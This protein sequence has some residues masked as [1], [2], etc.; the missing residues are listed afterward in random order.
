MT[1]PETERGGMPD[2][3]YTRLSKDVEGSPTMDWYETQENG[4]YPYKYHADHIHQ[5]A[6]AEIAELRGLVEGMS[7]SLADI[8]ILAM[9]DERAYSPEM[10]SVICTSEANRI[11]EIVQ[12]QLTAYQAY[13]EKMDGK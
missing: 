9:R 13:K 7:G 2:V 12:K 10:R 11:R 1:P 5:A 8:G 4:H 6:L 3:I